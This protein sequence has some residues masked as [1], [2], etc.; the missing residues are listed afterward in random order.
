MTISTIF[1]IGVFAFSLPPT[2]DP[3]TFGDKD[4]VS[5]ID[6]EIFEG[7]HGTY[8]YHD[9]SSA[10]NRAELA[11]RIANLP[12]TDEM[13]QALVACASE[14]YPSYIAA[15]GDVASRHVKQYFKISVDLV[16]QSKID[17]KEPTARM[18]LNQNR[19]ADEIQ[20]E[21]ISAEHDFIQSVQICLDNAIFNSSVLDDRDSVG[22]NI[23]E[24]FNLRA[25]LEYIW[26][27]KFHQVQ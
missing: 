27:V 19:E 9:F 20:R 16:E 14:K 17:G 24:S 2:I 8:N 23:L 15:Q 7:K 10:L 22:A 12:I 25:D 26:K 18:F 6:K 11:D 4:P 3:K 5:F 21:L 13:R 1:T